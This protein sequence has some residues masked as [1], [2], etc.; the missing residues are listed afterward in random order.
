MLSIPPLFPLLPQTSSNLL[1]V[2][3]SLLFGRFHIN[4]VELN[5]S[6]H[7]WLILI[8][9]KFLMSSQYFLNTTHFV[10]SLVNSHWNIWFWLLWIMWVCKFLCLLLVDISFVLVMVPEVELLSLI[11]NLTYIYIFVKVPSFPVYWLLLPCSEH[12]GL[13]IFP[14]FIKLFTAKF[15]KCTRYLY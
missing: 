12:I 15:L 5:M 3:M 10:I 7:P 11:Y 14:W 8:C 13:L 4:V 2:S 9:L 1:F 6:F